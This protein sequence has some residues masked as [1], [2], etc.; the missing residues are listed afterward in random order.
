[1]FHPSMTQ[2]FLLSSQVKQLQ[3]F[4]SPRHGRGHRHLWLAPHRLFLG[5]RYRYAAIL[6]LRLLQGMHFK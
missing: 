2:V 1:M 3:S 5:H 4:F 6:P